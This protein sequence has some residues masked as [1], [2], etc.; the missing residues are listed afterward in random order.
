MRRTGNLSRNGLDEGRFV[1]RVAKS[2]ANLSNRGVDA[3]LDVDE[4]VLAPQPIDDVFAGHQLTSP[5]DQHD[6]EVHRL[7]FEPDRAAAAAQLVAGDVQ[8]ELA[9]AEDSARVGRLHHPLASARFITA[10]RSA[11]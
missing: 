4:D 8:L 2:P 9:E 3:G 5:L 11:T 1:R 6:Q 10:I 7:S